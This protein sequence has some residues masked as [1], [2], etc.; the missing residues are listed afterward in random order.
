MTER[1]ELSRMREIPEGSFV[2]ERTALG[3]RMRAS[4][5]A[6]PTGGGR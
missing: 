6:M 2:E 3:D 5:L 1:E 4:F